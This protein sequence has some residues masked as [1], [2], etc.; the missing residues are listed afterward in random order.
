VSNQIAAVVT[1]VLNGARWIEETMRSVLNQSAVRSGRVR[2]RY[3]VMDGGS[4]DG[5]VDIVR[6][7]G[8]DLVELVS[9]KDSGMYGALAKGFKKVAAGSDVC[10]YL[11]A[12]D[13]WHQDALDVVLEAFEI[14]GVDWLSGY[15]VAYNKAGQIVHLR[16]PFRYRNR[17]V[18][19]GRYGASLPAIQQESTFWRGSLMQVVDLDR[20]AS[21]QLAGDYYLWRSFSD[22]ATLHTIAAVLGGFRLHGGH[23]SDARSAYA[24]EVSEMTNRARVADKFFEYFDRI[25]WRAPDDVKKALG[26]GQMLRYDLGTGAWVKGKARRLPAHHAPA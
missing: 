16:L 19:A 1:P 11:N 18:A 7:V 9:E 4:T 10:A 17:L 3:V 24:A 14:A 12:G 5:T 21:F 23:L 20:L 15:R 8:A 6:A 25:A 2:L 13:L 26:R 22:R